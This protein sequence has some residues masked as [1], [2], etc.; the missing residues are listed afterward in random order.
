MRNSIHFQH[1]EQ[2]YLGHK[3]DEK[4][5]NQ[6]LPNNPNLASFINGHRDLLGKNL[7]VLCANFFELYTLDF[8]PKFLSENDSL[9]CNF[10][11]KQA[12]DREYHKLFDWEANNANKFFRLFGDEFK[13]K[14]GSE[15][16]EDIQLTQKQSQFMQLGR[17]RNNLV[18]EGFKSEVVERM[19]IDDIWEMFEASCCFYDFILEKLKAEK[20]HVELEYCI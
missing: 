18:H 13:E 2:I 19:S 1:V 20:N 16:K 10:L 3:E 15:I 4:L 12:L 6:L 17:L 11:K 5:L 8:L 7:I 9:L 14:V